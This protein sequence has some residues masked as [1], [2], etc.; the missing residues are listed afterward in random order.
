MKGSHRG[1]TNKPCRQCGKAIDS[2]NYCAGC[3]KQRE[4]KRKRENTTP[5]APVSDCPCCIELEIPSPTIT[6]RDAL[7]TDCTTIQRAISNLEPLDAINQNLQCIVVKLIETQPVDTQA[8]CSS[9]QDSIPT[10]GI[11]R[12]QSFPEENPTKK[13]CT[14]PTHIS[15]VPEDDSILRDILNDDNDQDSM[16]EPS[17]IESRRSCW[18]Q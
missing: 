2:R 9:G 14:S 11:K 6:N 16:S 8:H 15:V 1:K 13:P 7:L 12:K 5:H 4:R 17:D 18:I 10:I 3:Q